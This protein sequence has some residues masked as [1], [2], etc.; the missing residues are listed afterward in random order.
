MC[1]KWDEVRE[2]DTVLVANRGEI[3][4]RVIGTLR[5]LGLRTVAVFS[6][7]D[8]DAR[9]AAEADV[10]V[11][12]GSGRAAEN[13]L[14][15]GRLLDAAQRTGAQAIHPGYG[16]LSENAEF[17][18][19]CADAGVVFIGP[20]PAAIEAMG[21]KIRAKRAV[22][23]AGVPVVPGRSD[24]GM[25]DEDLAAS[26]A[27][28]GFPVLL[29]PSAGGGGKGMRTVRG[30][31][32]LP[33][34]VAAARREA[35]AAFG[36]DTLFVERFVDRPRHI[37]VQVLADAHG[38]VVHLGE[39]ECSLQRRH[40]K[41]VE[42]APSPL[43]DESTRQRIGQAAVDTARAVDYRGAGT[44][45]FIVSAD[46]PDEFFFM[47]MNTRLQVEHPV[48]EEV[49]AVSGRRGIDL[50]AEQVRIAEG[51]PLP[52]EQHRLG[53]AG[54]A[55]EAR[56]YAEDPARDFLPTGGE[57]LGLHE[58]SGPD[59]RVDSGLAPGTRIG[60]DYDPM[61]SKV[62]AWA[63][64][65]AAALR[66]LDSALADVAVLGVRT[67]VGFLRN[68]LAHPDVR[69]GRLDTGLV[70]R[71]LAGLVA[72]SAGIPEQVPVAAAMA[73]LLAAEPAGPIVDRWA[74]PDGWRLG[75]PAWS[76]WRFSTG[77][78]DVQVRVRG[79]AHAAEAAVGGEV[80][81][82]SARLDG[83]LL[84]VTWGG[85]TERYRFV[86]SDGVDWLGSGGRCWALTEQRLLTD[87]AG[88]GGR[89]DG[90]VASPMPGT[91][92]VA[93]VEAGQRV[94]SGQR[95]F[96]VEAM[97]ME[98]TVTAPDDGVVAEV[99]ARAGQPVG[100]DEPLAVLTAGQEDRH[101]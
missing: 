76:T 98:H 54:H 71:D 46:R 15:P 24:P 87:P 84:T 96:V 42:E 5:R 74:V 8:R 19:A 79:R 72:D 3:A 55:V 44:V 62:I 101:G 83:D 14:H 100:L 59:V 86:R 1:G 7:A 51:K 11:H 63:P 36:D 43:L 70:E 81:P 4:V 73:G 90:V 95:L 6:E 78:D 12:L 9:H 67:N 56:V 77:G 61:L 37:E 50:V 33:E 85:C 52:F 17:A 25:T 64:E 82:A 49:T 27:E 47:E 10:A 80:H 97:K 30:P 68:L 58:P 57:V 94:S 92:L 41:I 48:T 22:R 23:E 34:A 35:G 20:P 2:F 18:A 53:M 26:A 29:K 65:R 45:E 89:S 21:D 31:A 38:G 66:R 88:S 93:D 75:E 91:V 13:Y 69:S 99:H 32:E 16:F 39:R 28:I 40:Q 60:S